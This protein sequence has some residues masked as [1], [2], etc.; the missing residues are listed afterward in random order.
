M[1]A[2]QIDLKLAKLFGRDRNVRK[3]TK[4]GVD[5]VNN[6]TAGY[7]VLDEA[8]RSFN[9]RPRAASERHFSAVGN[10]GGLFER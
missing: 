6:F 10:R 8:A 4:A 5:S 7:Y 3:R 2:N 9:A 1:R